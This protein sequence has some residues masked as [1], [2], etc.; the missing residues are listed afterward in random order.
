MLKF[1]YT[2]V[3]T[4]REGD[5]WMVNRKKEEYS[6]GAEELWNEYEKI[7][8][9]RHII[10]SGLLLCVDDEDYHVIEVEDS[11]CA[12]LGFQQDEF[13]VR[14]GGKAGELIYKDDYKRVLEE[15]REQMLA[16]GEF[17]C[18]YRLR[19]KDGTLLW[20]WETG[21]RFQDE[22]GRML[23]RS[24]LLDINE[25]E[26]K[27]QS[28]MIESI[29]SGVIFVQIDE[30]DFTIVHG[31]KKFFELLGV[32]KE[33][34]IAES[35]H[36][37]CP[38]DLPGLK[39]YVCKQAQKETDLDYEFRLRGRTDEKEIW[40]RFIGKFY[41]NTQEGK[42]EYICVSQDV[43]NKYE[44]Q[45]QIERKS[46][47][48]R[49]ALQSTADI[50]FDY[51]V[52]KDVL[53]LYPREVSKGKT[54]DLKGGKYRDW[55]S[56]LWDDGTLVYPEDRERFMEFFK[57]PEG[58]E[59]EVRLRTR[60]FQQDTTCYQ[61][62][63]MRAMA[64]ERDGETNHIL[65]SI[66]NIEE[67]KELSLRN[68]ELKNLLDLQLIQNFERI[69]QVNSKTG[70]YQMYFLTEDD[71]CVR[72]KTGSHDDR[73]KYMCSN[74]VHEDDR[75]RYEFSMNFQRIKELLSTGEREMLRYFRI[76]S[77]GGE[78]RWK[79]Y[80]IS[81]LSSDLSVILLSVQ[82][83]HDIRQEEKEQEE[84]TRHLLMNALE[85]AKRS[86]GQKQIFL[87]TLTKEVR[88]PLNYLLDL[89][90]QAQEKESENK[91]NELLSQVEVVIGY[92]TSVIGKLEEL[93]QYEKG[94]LPLSKR[95]IELKAVIEKILEEQ[96]ES[97]RKRNV[98][99]YKSH[100]IPEGQMYYADEFRIQQI[101]SNALANAIRFSEQ[102]S[103]IGFY[104][105]IEEV[106]SGK[107]KLIVS[108]EDTGAYISEDYFERVYSDED[109][110]EEDGFYTTDAIGF[111]LMLSKKLAELLGG[112]VKVLHGNRKSNYFYIDIPLELSDK[113]ALES[114]V[115]VESKLPVSE[116]DL[117]A[118][119]ILYIEDGQGQSNMTGALLKINGANLEMAESGRRGFRMWENNIMEPY[120]VVL[121]DSGVQDIGYMKLAEMI[122]ERE[123]VRSK[124]VPIVILGD[125][126]LAENIKSGYHVG[127]NSFLPRP[128]NLK[129]LQQVLQVIE[130][131]II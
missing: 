44:L 8:G 52:K 11:L 78:Y 21:V 10:K 40:Y 37:V 34:Y 107:H 118:Y 55:R 39:N 96:E 24:L 127:I 90:Y 80:R 77:K 68:R 7:S 109:F 66:Q 114:E 130:G 101:F 92:L 86:S 102:G 60:D 124:R 48:Y 16:S 98:T 73:V 83:I 12:M 129:K 9:I 64:T 71:P 36:Y 47:Q 45:Q 50:G 23:I 88:T 13:F 89:C 27:H 128:L 94:I 62:Y 105:E 2:V 42:K 103:T 17:S 97:A 57:Q 111:S 116:V 67:Q 19:K 76:L 115:N 28:M 108:I 43:T 1:V 29:P 122:R 3:Y 70:Q 79:C 58:F 117:S 84:A 56:L 5:V 112:R 15:I 25:M 32:S 121:I 6:T 75:E 74:F 131:G 61:W 125:N 33:Q 110:V 91:E 123:S 99:I 93:N 119:R 51:D 41:G 35:V 22:D 82:D 65:G 120:S 95:N 31:N 100:S 49:L 30:Q 59:C 53:Y 106:N 20:V 18:K 85:E 14:C 113:R 69:I 26:Q 126:F 81:F 46:E 104:A 4:V 38:E 54:I 87:E 63:E 72:L